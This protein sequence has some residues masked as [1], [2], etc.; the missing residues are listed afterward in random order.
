M[1]LVG[2]IP[3]LDLK[4]LLDGNLRQQLMTANTLKRVYRHDPGKLQ[5]LPRISRMKT[6]QLG[7]R[8]E[9]HFQPNG[10]KQV[11]WLRKSCHD[12]QHR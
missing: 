8:G 2:P 4:P 5:I 6:K 3:R 12:L 9:A 1:R 11:Y 7:V 10:A